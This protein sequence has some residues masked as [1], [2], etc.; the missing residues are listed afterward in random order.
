MVREYII[1]AVGCISV[2]V[3]LSF[4]VVGVAQRLGI[5]ILGDY[6]W[7]ESR[8][9]CLFDEENRPYR[10]AGSHTDISERKSV[11]KALERKNR[12]LS[13]AYKDLKQ[14][15]AKILQQD[16]MAS[17]GLLAAGVAHEINNPTGFILS[18]LGTLSR[19]MIK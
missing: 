5:N 12:Q 3:V 19:Y 18:N 4:V 15:Q 16:K 8:G 1:L 17:I 9:I 11:A 7:V 14:T 13:D 2:G 10:M 6:L